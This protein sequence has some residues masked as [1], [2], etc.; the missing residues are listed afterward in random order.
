VSI[1][2][3]DVEADAVETKPLNTAQ[4]LL[5][6]FGVA[7]SRRPGSQRSSSYTKKGPGRYHQKATRVEL[8]ARRTAHLERMMAAI[9]ASGVVSPTGRELASA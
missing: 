4:Q 6:S 3:I 2:H 5:A 9:K 8:Q 1:A 7:W